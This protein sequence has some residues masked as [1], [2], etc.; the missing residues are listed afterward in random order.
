VI[1]FG[2]RYAV[3]DPVLSLWPFSQIP[4]HR[5]RLDLLYPEPLFSHCPSPRRGQ[6]EGAV[7][8]SPLLRVFK[9]NSEEI[10]GSIATLI[11]ISETAD[12][13]AIPDI[14]FLLL[15]RNRDVASCAARAVSALTRSLKPAEF[16]WLDHLMRERS[17]YRWAYSSSWVEL[18]PRQLD[19]FQTLGADS[20]FALG[21]ASFHSSGHVREEALLRLSDLQDGTELP[22]YGIGG[23]SQG[24]R[25]S[26]AF[27]RK[28]DKT[29]LL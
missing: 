5:L 2:S 25:D 18:Q 24:C 10:V 15:D 8:G 3:F 19:H 6:S 11:S 4:L 1:P 29:S 21:M 17:P 22:S 9:Q 16:P 23:G 28:A 20:V 14:V 12:P 27:A 26:I 13:A 7:H